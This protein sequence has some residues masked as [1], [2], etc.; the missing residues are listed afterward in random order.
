[1]T[2]NLLGFDIK[3]RLVTNP[4]AK[5]DYLVLL[6]GLNNLGRI[7]NKSNLILDISSINETALDDLPFLS[8]YEYTIYEGSG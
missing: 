7:S 5:R 3:E 6:L 4:D 8:I 2:A 1:M